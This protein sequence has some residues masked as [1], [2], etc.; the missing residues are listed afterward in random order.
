M[1]SVSSCACLTKVMEMGTD[2][3]RNVVVT[4]KTQTVEVMKHNTDISLEEYREAVRFLAITKTAYIFKNSSPIHANIV[5]TNIIDN[6]ENSIVIYEANFSVDIAER[7]KE[8]YGAMERLV[9]AGKE[10]KIAVDSYSDKESDIYQLLKKLHSE[11]PTKVHVKE[12]SKEFRDN[13][14]S[15]F[16]DLLNFVVGDWNSFRLVET[17]LDDLNRRRA[18]CSFNNSRTATALRSAFEDKFEMCN[19]IF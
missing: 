9:K 3:N 1:C 14:E 18:F 15:E 13:I 10:L 4:K 5:L 11:Y 12:A 2:S 17:K 8:F 19:N 16:N 6:A 7:R